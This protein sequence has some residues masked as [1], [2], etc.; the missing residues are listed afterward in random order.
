MRLGIWPK[1]QKVLSG[2]SIAFTV[3]DREGNS[4]IPDS[5][6]CYSL[7]GV[8]E[9][10][11]PLYKE[12][13][14]YMPL[15][16]VPGFVLIA[17]CEDTPAA[18]DRFL[19]ADALIGAMAEAVS[20]GNDINNA[21]A[22]ILTNELALPE[23]DA[24]VD[25][26]HMIRDSAR[27]VM[28]MHMIQVK[29]QTAYDILNEYLPRSDGDLMISMD[30][31]TVAFIKAVSSGDETEDLRQYAC[32]ARETVV[33]ETALQ[34]TIGIG[35]ITSDVSELHN[36]YRQARRA[37]EIGRVFKPGQDVLVYSSMMLERFL[38]TLSAETAMH[39]HSLLFAPE[40]SRLFNTEML[41]TI[42]MFFKKDLNLSDTARQ[43]FIHRNTLVYRLD[44]IQRQTGLDLRHFDDA[45]TFKMLYDMEK[46][47]NNQ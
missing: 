16:A 44:K 25:E 39:Y 21:Y 4:V 38:S 32:A 24:I 7:P 28:L 8:M 47:K 26:Y 22:R 9:R 17:A 13:R 33:G 34:L 29:Q 23:L 1:V 19:L 14:L 40:N 46:C 30:R 35:C 42:E 3:T 45:V 43:L 31:H 36:S 5:D 11:E 41:E 37:I 10:G 15:R 27:C 12:G 18:K 20:L 6:I 2:L